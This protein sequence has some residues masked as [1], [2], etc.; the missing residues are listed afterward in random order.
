M[1]T[2]A[3]LLAMMAGVAKTQLVN[4]AANIDVLNP[5]VVLLVEELKDAIEDGEIAGTDAN[6][7][8]VL[9]EIT[10]TFIE[11]SYRFGLEFNNIQV[12]DGVLVT[13]AVGDAILAR[14]D[15]EFVVFD[16][17]QF[18]AANN[19]L[20]DAIAAND[21]F[22]ND[23]ANLDAQDDALGLFSAIL[24]AEDTNNHSPSVFCIT[25]TQCL[26]ARG[27]NPNFQGVA[28]RECQGATDGV[29]DGNGIPTC[30]D[31]V[32]FFT[33]RWL[34]FVIGAVYVVI[35]LWAL[36]FGYPWL[37]KRSAKKKRGGAAKGGKALFNDEQQLIVNTL[38]GQCASAENMLFQA[39]DMLK[40]AKNMQ[41]ILA[42]EA[43]RESKLTI[44]TCEYFQAMSSVLVALCH[45]YLHEK[46]F[47]PNPY[48]QEECSV[49]AMQLEV[50]NYV[51]QRMQLAFSA[52]AFSDKS[53]LRVAEAYV[54]LKKIS[55]N[56]VIVGFTSD[57]EVDGSLGMLRTPVVEL[58]ENA[59]RLQG[60]FV[61]P[62]GGLQDE[63]N[64]QEVCIGID[65]PDA[66]IKKISP[67][68]YLSDTQR[69]AMN[70]NPQMGGVTGSTG[71]SLN[72]NLVNAGTA[73]ESMQYFVRT[74]W[75]E[76]VSALQA[77][78]QSWLTTEGRL[79]EWLDQERLEREQRAAP[80]VRRGAKKKRKKNKKN[81]KKYKDSEE[82]GSQITE[83]TE[84]SGWSVM[85]SNT[86]VYNIQSLTNQGLGIAGKPG[87][88]YDK[89]GT[90][91]KETGKWFAAW[92]YYFPNASEW[93][94]FYIFIFIVMPI[95]IHIPMLLKARQGANAIDIDGNVGFKARVAGFGISYLGVAAYYFLDGDVPELDDLV[96]GDA[97]GP[98]GEAL[99]LIEAALG[100]DGLDP[101]NN[102]GAIFMD[103]NFVQGLFEDFDGASG[104]A[105]DVFS[106]EVQAGVL[107]QN[108]VAELDSIRSQRI[109]QE[110][111]TV[112]LYGLMHTGAYF[113][114]IVPLSLIRESLEIL[115]RR[116]PIVRDVY[117]MSQWRELHMNLGLGGI[118]FV[119]FGSTVFLTTQLI[120]IGKRTP[121]AGLGGDP[122]IADFFELADNVLYIRQLLL[123]AV[124]L[125][126]LMK[127]ASRGPPGPMRKYAPTWMTL[128]YWEICYFLH[129]VTA[130]TAII[131][132]VIYRPQVFYWMGATWGIV[133][134]G[135]KIIRILRTSRTTI[136][137]TN[138]VSYTVE[139]KRNNAK[140]RSD[141]CRITLNV[142]ESFTS[143]ARGQACWLTIPHIDYVAHPFTLAKVPKDD[144]K[145]IMFHI[146]IKY[147]AGDDII[148]YARPEQKSLKKEEPAAAPVDPNAMP[149]GWSSAVDEESGQTY[150][151]NA[152][153]NKTQWERP[154][155]TV[156]DKIAANA[157]AMTTRFS[158]ANIR[159][160]QSARLGQV[161]INSGDGSNVRGFNLTHRAT[162]TQ[163]LA[164]LGDML[165][166]MDDDLR[167]NAIKN[168]PVYVSAPLGTSMDDALKPSL[169]GSIIITTQ[170]GLPA[171][172]S[173][174]RWLL[175]QKKAQRPKFHFF[176][177]V[178]REVNDALSVVETLRDAM[179][180]AVV[181]GTLDIDGLNP[182]HAH[183]ADWLGV[184]INLTRRT[185]KQIDG[186]RD[187]LMRSLNPPSS[188]VTPTQL[189][190]I[191]TWLKYR[192]QPGRLAFDRFLQ[193]T[194]QMIQKRTG[195]SKMAVAYCGSAAVAYSIRAS[196]RKT[197]DCTFDGEFI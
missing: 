184:H 12:V 149:V 83:Y 143:G 127:Y 71:K 131:T 86:Y 121:F 188:P 126:L 44:L 33:L 124:P 93:P 85:S 178:S 155:A 111:T 168:Y 186:D 132:L 18:G 150:Y 61:S 8:L 136:K 38:A 135:N 17:V 51:R 195:A 162:W 159:G 128:N 134:G 36:Y 74:F 163:R 117:P 177:S 169:P 148:A 27:D 91:D 160:G 196:C 156:G 167:R 31:F 108:N 84:A 92:E 37:K 47:E 197:K 99:G 175:A 29:N 50:L 145:T 21:L 68:N 109:A 114:G 173:S 52:D 116:F 192:V 191:E 187:M 73:G 81:K 166:S 82:T 57:M 139:D 89:L 53:L 62:R 72:Y 88:P 43:R 172:E 80:M 9:G 98:E 16:N 4:T 1:I 104:R 133:W 157:R 32:A 46:A 40:Q 122:N 70:Y 105:A 110:V 78:A 174:V 165:N 94:K 41:S 138:L 190:M 141:V 67:N 19:A 153:M 65:V 152:N 76:D 15:R 75:G 154:T 3:A 170:N 56:L 28:R 13:D 112:W 120:S 115:A 102:G 35:I 183:M 63:Y 107:A 39:T 11:G 194:S 54:V 113:F 6:G 146:G 125:L 100:A 42:V 185:P 140:K 182:R 171:A 87:L 164:K 142:P 22:V 26:G 137:S 34:S 20:E 59:F 179:C 79:E 66:A 30:N 49:R 180:D 193:R 189:E 5:D 129:Y 118:Y 69:D 77:E 25:D 7:D 60:T 161:N 23:Q 14:L 96:V 48:S 55:E 106:A 95:L 130:L 144:D 97:N 90:I 181:S 64:G 2:K 147:L 176:V 10:A 119:T 101:F 151:Y 24:V 158:I 103:N 45:Q 58:K 123:P